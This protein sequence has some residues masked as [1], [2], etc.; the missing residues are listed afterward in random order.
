MDK[1]EYRKGIVL[2]I[3][4]AIIW[5]SMGLIIRQM[6]VAGTWAILFYRSLGALPMLLGI[7]I[8]TGGSGAAGSLWQRIRAAGLPGVIG[9]FA[10]VLSF[11]GSIFALQ[12]TTVANATF[13][14]A[15]NPPIAAV[16][17][18]IILGERVRPLTWVSILIAASGIFVMVNE[19]LSSGAL[20]GNIAALLT[21]FGFASYTIAL[22]WRRLSDMIPAALVG[23]FLSTILAGAAAFATGDTLALPLG[24]LARG[25]GL[26]VFV[27]GVGMGLYTFGS[28]HVTAAELGILLLLELTLGPLWVWLVIGE[29]TSR[30]T[31]LG[32]AILLKAVTLNA[33]SGLWRDRSFLTA[34]ETRA[35]V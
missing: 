24:D 10:L 7:M 14:F 16:L 34:K 29:T 17:G 26:G 9:G 22:R 28:R 25:L 6:E 4:A 8:L 13:L 30:A 35:G 5:S 1:S 19:G 31:M 33:A 2:V 23:A 3:M 20:A 27:L 18:W 15:S 11:A 21:G 12:H 32:G